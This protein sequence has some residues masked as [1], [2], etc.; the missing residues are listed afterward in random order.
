MSEIAVILDNPEKVADL[1][2]NSL[3]NQSTYFIQILLV[4]TFLGV[5]FELLRVLPLI[6]AFIRSRVGPNLTEAERNRKW[7]WF[8]PLAE[9][10]EFEYANVTSNAILYFMILF[11]YSTI[12]PITN[13]F[14]AF[15]FMMLNSAYRHQFVYA[16]P[17]TV[18]CICST[19]ASRK[20]R[21][22]RFL[23]YI[24]CSPIQAGNYGLILL[25]LF[26]LAC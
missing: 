11:V 19:R 5:S 2:A 23:H 1:L 10:L 18:S 9:P 13:W 25:E 8:N 7:W 12:A 17:T 4:Q 22:G 15:C 21:H 20:V 16:Y 26:K 14:M 24:V 3:P 6:Y